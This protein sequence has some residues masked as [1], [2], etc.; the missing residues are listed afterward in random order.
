[1]QNWQ[2]VSSYELEASW[3]SLV[4][5]SELL[6]YEILKLQL[7]LF[8]FFLTLVNSSRLA[9]SYPAQSRMN[10][11]TKTATHTVSLQGSDNATQHTHTHT[12]SAMQWVSSL[13]LRGS[14]KCCTTCR[15]GGG[16]KIQLF[17][18]L[19]INLQRYAS[20]VSQTN[21]LKLYKCYIFLFCAT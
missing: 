14:Q 17:R 4:A 12:E 1:M 3:F 21:L 9:P 11:K 8:S 16:I 13:C 10:C 2:H 7:V 5:V 18:S 6:Y 15:E 19:F 20:V